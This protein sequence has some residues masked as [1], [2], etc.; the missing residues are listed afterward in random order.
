MRSKEPKRWTR[1]DFR[2]R[3]T[4]TPEPK[5]CNG[6]LQAAP[7]HRHAALRPGQDPHLHPTSS[8]LFCERRP[9]GAEPKQEVM[10]DKHRQADVSGRERELTVRV[11]DQCS[12]RVCVCVCVLQLSSSS[13]SSTTSHRTKSFLLRFPPKNTA[14][15]FKTSHVGE[16]ELFL[17]LMFSAVKGRRLF[18]FFV[19]VFSTAK[20]VNDNE[21]DNAS[22]NR[23]NG[24]KIGIICKYQ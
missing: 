2:I 19:C 14:T 4:F 15:F 3:F 20:E 10:D 24:R 8:S 17:P 7:W 1:T 12:A 6:S 16:K 11:G 5:L 18:V 9:A 13:N 21:P 23:K 22:G